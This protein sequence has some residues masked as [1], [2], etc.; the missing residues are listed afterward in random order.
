VEELVT[1]GPSDLEYDPQLAV[2][3]EWRDAET[4]FDAHLDDA[5]LDAMLEGA[6]DG[7]DVEY[8]WPMLGVARVMKA[9]SAAKVL[10]GSTGPVPEGMS[11]TVALRVA[12]LRERHAA[13]R[14]VLLR[15][16]NQFESAE[17]YRPPFWELRRLAIESERETDPS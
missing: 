13:I 5:I 10:F 11:A 16:V 17:G 4:L 6:A 3:A 12:W 9:Y 15:K 7:D 1:H 14:A 2:V 8:S